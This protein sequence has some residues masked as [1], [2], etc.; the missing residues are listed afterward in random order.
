MD[1]SRVLENWSWA[2]AAIA[3]GGV[4]IITLLVRYPRDVEAACE[5]VG[6]RLGYVSRRQAEQARLERLRNLNPPNRRKRIH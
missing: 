5:A 6:K 4:L 2:Q 1:I 3:S